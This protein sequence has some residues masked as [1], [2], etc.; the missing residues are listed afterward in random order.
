MSVY[1]Y[2]HD[3]KRRELDEHLRSNPNDVNAQCASVSSI[4][5][6]IFII[7]ITTIEWSDSITS[8]NHGGTF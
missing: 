4:I 2:A 5:V 3:G 6:I 7:I 8:S 1:Q